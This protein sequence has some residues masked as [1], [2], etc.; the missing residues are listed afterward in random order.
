MRADGQ[1]LALAV[2]SSD[3][4]FLEGSA[5]LATTRLACSLRASARDTPGSTLTLASTVAEGRVGWH[6]VTAVGDGVSLRSSDVPATS[7]SAQ[8]TAYPQDLLQS[9]PE[10]RD[11]TIEVGPV[12]GAA[13]GSPGPRDNAAEAS[14]DALRGA[15]R[16][17][18]AYTDLVSTLD[19]SWGVAV[20]AVLAS[21]VLGGLH[22]F[23][24]GHGK[25]LMAAYLVGK[26]GSLRQAGL[27]GL[28][29]TA[30]HTLGVL[31]LGVVLSTAVVAAPEHIYP[32]LSLTSG[33]L[34]VGIGAVLLRQGLARRRVLP[35][36]VAEPVLVGAAAPHPPGDHAHGADHHPP[37]PTPT[38]IMRLG[39]RTSTSLMMTTRTTTRTTTERPRSPTPTAARRTPRPA[40][41]VVAQPR[42][43]RVRR[44]SGAQPVGAGR[45]ARRDRAWAD[46]VRRAARRR[47]RRRDGGS[48]GGRR[49][50]AHTR[51]RLA[52]TPP[53]RP[54]SRR[55]SCVPG[56][57]QSGQRCRR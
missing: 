4:A 29:V 36:P 49:T 3:V 11:A 43:G 5:G 28:S 56:P 57:A 46:L 30:T 55:R 40:A 20:L 37:T 7:A 16:I 39:L 17:T 32:W 14:T 12:G 54:P 31:V 48:T 44:R 35:G 15:G 10:V 34:L 24:P 45:A 23:A 42:G 19:L 27:I 18:G 21:V 25:T 41:H 50:P 22:A 9:P 33:L 1:P 13:A 47:L 52:R 8:L 53:R 6:E 38:V 51:P 26:N 2:T